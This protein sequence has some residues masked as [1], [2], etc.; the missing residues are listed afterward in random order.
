MTPQLHEFL[1][2]HFT[3][4]VNEKGEE[5]E[6]PEKPIAS[7]AIQSQ[8]WLLEEYDLALSE[9]N[10]AKEVIKLPT[11]EEFVFKIEELVNHGVNVNLMF[12]YTR[13]INQPLTLSMFVPVKDGKV[14]EEPKYWHKFN[15]NKYFSHPIKTITEIDWEDYQTALDQVIFEGWELADKGRSHTEIAKCN[16][17]ITFAKEITLCA[18]GKSYKLKT[19]S[20]GI[21]LGLY[22]KTYST[23]LEYSS[24]NWRSLT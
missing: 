18:K 14:L 6:K 5:V 2:Q 4:R 16:N 15:P 23:S 11:L 13:F 9:Y 17:Q 7:S 3:I 20:D 12:D 8:K 22:L 21:Q 1:S 19:I 10:N 24:G